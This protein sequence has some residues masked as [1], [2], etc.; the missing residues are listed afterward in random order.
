MAETADALGC[1]EGTV[2]NYTSRALDAMRRVLGVDVFTIEEVRHAHGS[3]RPA[4]RR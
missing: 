2:K 3:A 1:P 4:A